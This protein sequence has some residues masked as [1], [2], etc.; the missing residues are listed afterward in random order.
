[1]D[2]RTLLR[3]LAA[4]TIGTAFTTIRDNSAAALSGKLPI[5]L[6]GYDYDRVMGLINGKVGIEKCDLT[7]ETDTIGGLNTDALGGPMSRDA[8][9]IGLVPYILAYTRGQ[10]QNHTLIPVF[11]LRVFR[12]KSIYVRPDRG[13]EKPEDLRGK[14]IATPGFS[15]SSLTW[16]RGLMADEYGVAP[17]DI[18]WVISSKDSS[19]K[20]SGGPSRFESFV[21]SG[22]TI[23]KGSDGKDESDLLVSGEVDAL[24]HAAEPR[25]FIGQDPNCVRLFSDSRAVEQAYYKTTGIF[26]IMHVVAV[27]KDVA[28]AHPWLPKALFRAYSRAKKEVYAFQRK[29]GWYKLTQPWISQELEE[30]RLVM[31]DNFYSYGFTGNNRKTLDALLR[32]CHAQGLA[33]RPLSVAELFHSSTLDLTEE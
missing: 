8:T 33:D 14:K 24:F 17:K 29:Q 11:P 9:E 6:A 28:E 22:L 32:Y 19:G 23:T 2:R 16:I 25:A 7:F 3:F 15:S 13:I 18:N 1:M 20:D 21:P 5:R 10:L 27:R 30:T 31:G 12:H 26:P 4:T